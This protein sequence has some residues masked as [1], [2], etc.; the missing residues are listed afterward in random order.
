M[1]EISQLKHNSLDCD[2]FL[3]NISHSLQNLHVQSLTQ[4]KKLHVQN[5]QFQEWTPC[6]FQMS[7]FYQMCTI[8]FENWRGFKH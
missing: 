3:K 6:F 7:F 1:F 8:P 5:I 2:N 4:K